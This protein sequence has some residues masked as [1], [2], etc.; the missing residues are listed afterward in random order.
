M[1]QRCY[2][3]NSRDYKYYGG[4]GIDV[5]HEWHDFKVFIDDV[6]SGY[7]QGLKID[8]RDNNAGYS[9]AN[10][11]WATHREQCNNRR[12][13]HIITNPDTGEQFNIQQL[14]DKYKVPRPTINSRLLRGHVRFD[15]LVQRGHLKTYNVKKGY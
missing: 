9:K 3:P 14:A 5:A 8:R 10:C 6:S 1:M 7:R 15:Q 11:W 13:N 4:R 12:S 2:N